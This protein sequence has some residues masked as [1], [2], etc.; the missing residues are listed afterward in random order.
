MKKILTILSLALLVMA[1]DEMYGPIPVSESPVYSSGIDVQ[2]SQVKDSSFVVNLTPKDEALF[3]T[4]LVTEESTPQVLDSA[5][6]Y[7]LSYKGVQNGKFNFKEQSSATVELTDLK[8]NTAYQVYAVTSSKTGIPSAVTVKSVVTSDSYSPFI[9]SVSRNGNKVTV[10]FSENVKYDESKDVTA[11]GYSKVY[12]S[13]APVVASAKATVTVSGSAATFEFAA[14]KTPGTYYTVAYPE[15]TFVDETGNSCQAVE[16]GKFTV[17]TDGKYT[18]SYSGTVYGFLA[19]ADLSYKL[20]EIKSM[21]LADWNKSISVNVPDGVARVDLKDGYVTVVEHKDASGMESVTKWPMKKMTNYYGTYYDVVM[22]LAG[23]A[24][25]GDMV[26][27]V[28]PAG[29]VMDWYGNVNASAIEVGPIEMMVP[30]E[31]SFEDA[32]IGSCTAYVSVSTNDVTGKK[33]WIWDYGTKEEMEAYSD[34]DFIADYVDYIANDAE[35]NE[36]SFEE[37]LV[38]Y[39]A[40]QGDDELPIIN[41]E[42][43]TSYQMLGFFIDA[44]GN[45]ISDVFRHDFTT[46]ALEVP[47][48]E[49]G[50]YNFSLWY[51]DA[52]ADLPFSIEEA[53]DGYL[54]TISGLGE[55]F[56]L[57]FSMDKDGNCYV[58]KTEVND[59]FSYQGSEFPVYL[60]EIDS[61]NEEGWDSTSYY[62]QVKKTFVFTLAYYIDLGYLGY[63]DESFELDA[64]GVAATAAPASLGSLRKGAGSLTPG[65]AIAVPHGRRK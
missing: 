65:K 46:V 26:S 51:E 48:E 20:P 62:D 12:A 27:I 35:S 64:D 60:E 34:E 56:D 11:V 49:T 59:T 13:G 21:F 31:L 40:F 38:D 54:C 23:E 2:V 28:I 24:Q 44:E 18:V 32:G 30:L 57:T 39:Y 16:A 17:S 61:W 33:F 1:C 19:N 9:K 55:G 15:G 4:Y 5:K 3:Y 45:A 6:L 14:F 37:M 50:T 8:P 22:T 52:Q 7:S 25:P 10:T 63:G 58:P 43:E 41:L 29:A 42:A 47:E 36:M 53:E